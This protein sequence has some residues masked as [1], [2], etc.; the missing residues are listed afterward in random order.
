MFSIDQKHVLIHGIGGATV[1][2]FADA[3][4]RRN[5]GDVFAKFRVENIPT[6]PDMAIERV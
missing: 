2:I 3:L 6:D 5:R 4:L 1:P